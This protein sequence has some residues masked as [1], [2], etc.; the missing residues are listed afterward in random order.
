MKLRAVIVSS[1]IKMTKDG[2]VVVTQFI[3]KK[4][5]TSSDE[6]AR[7]MGHEVE[8]TIEPLQLEMFRPSV[9]PE[10]GEILE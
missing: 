7:L 2:Q 3:S 1:A 4:K 6:L 9:D 5:E 8:I 10:T